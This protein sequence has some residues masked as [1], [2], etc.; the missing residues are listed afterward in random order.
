MR[1]MADR[2]K[3]PGWGIALTPADLRRRFTYG[4]VDLAA[5][6]AVANALTD[7]TCLTR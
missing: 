7:Y 4:L 1:Q 6:L 3:D 5:W 2:R